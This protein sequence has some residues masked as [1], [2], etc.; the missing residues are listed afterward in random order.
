MEGDV[1]RH[2]PDVE[3]LPADLPEH[4]RDRNDLF[5]PVIEQGVRAHVAAQPEELLVKV[6][7]RGHD[8]HAPAVLVEVE[9]RRG[10]EKQALA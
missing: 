2:R 8:H 6:E 4:L 9:P 5:Q 3:P 10:V 7:V 1:A